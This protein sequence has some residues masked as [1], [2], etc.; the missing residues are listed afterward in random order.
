MNFSHW[1]YYIAK[2]QFCDGQGNVDIDA[3][4]AEVGG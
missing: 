4:S 1:E 3:E 2:V